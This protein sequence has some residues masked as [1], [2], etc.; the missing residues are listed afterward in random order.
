MNEKKSDQPVRI[1]LAR[2]PVNSAEIFFII[3]P[4]IDR[5]TRRH[6]NPASDCDDVLLWNEKEEI[7]ESCIANIVA[8]IDGDL[9]TPPVDSGLLAGTFREWLLDQGKIV[10]G[11]KISD[12]GSVLKN[13]P[14]KFRPQM[15]GSQLI[16]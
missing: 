16:S 12:L 2:E 15:A 14:D 4:H 5:F 13:L 1:A 7:T 6:G 3:K 9:F 8:E 10:N 11:I